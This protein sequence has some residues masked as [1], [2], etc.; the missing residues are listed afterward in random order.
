M[1]VK[2]FTRDYSIILE[3]TWFQALNYGIKNLFNIKVPKKDFIISFFN[4]GVIEL[5]S[6]QAAEQ[7]LM[8]EIERQVNVDSRKFNKI[9]DSYFVKLEGL[10][11]FFK[12]KQTKQKD[13]LNNFISLMEDI[14]PYF[15]VS[16]YIADKTLGSEDIIKRAEKMRSQDTLF[17]DADSYIRKSMLSIFP[18]VHDL[19][20]VVLKKDLLAMPARDILEKRFKNFVFTYHEETQIIDLKDYVQDKGYSFDFIEADSSVSSIEG[21]TA[22]PGRAKG[23]VR[24][25]RRNNEIKTF[26]AGEILVSPMTT[27]DYLAA[28]KK[29]VAIITDEGGMLCHAAIIAREMQK[30][31]VIGTKIATKVLKDGDMVEVD[32]DRGVI[33]KI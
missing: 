3:E 14:M 19:E 22:W 11:I 28:M 18:M 31:C 8:A 1:Y 12:N 7:E 15:V 21:M 17:V 23:R 10:Q 9:I 26:Q 33:R 27:P 6:D 16:Y 20:T 25:I 29:S 5:W 32:A 24:V 30:P 13:I 2:E 4:N